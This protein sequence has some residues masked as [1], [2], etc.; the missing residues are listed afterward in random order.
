ML[1]ASWE[2]ARELQRHRHASMTHD[3]SEWLSFGR[4]C[5]RARAPVRLAVTGL[6]RLARAAFPP[7]GLRPRWIRY[8]IDLADTPPP[9]PHGRLAPP[10]DAILGARRARPARAGPSFQ[11]GVGVWGV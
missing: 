1:P 11:S 7:Q 4:A 8:R 5:C 6:L 2:C 3:T 9:P 10:T